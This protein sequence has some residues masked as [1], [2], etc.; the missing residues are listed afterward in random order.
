MTCECGDMDSWVWGATPD[1]FFLWYPFD[2]EDA[3]EYL[4]HRTLWGRPIWAGVR[5]DL[6]DAMKWDEASFTDRLLTEYY[7]YLFP[8]DRPGKGGGDGEPLKVGAGV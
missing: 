8:D 4:T 3:V 6:A 2:T 1:P 7:Y 5:Q